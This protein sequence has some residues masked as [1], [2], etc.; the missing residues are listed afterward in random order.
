MQN[1]PSQASNHNEEEYDIQKI[2]D[3]ITSLKNRLMEVSRRSNANINL[4]GNLFS[5]NS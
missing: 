1:A 3:K 2:V 4:A 5:G